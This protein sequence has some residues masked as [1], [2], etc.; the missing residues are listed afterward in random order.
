M[1]DMHKTYVPTP[2][3]VLYSPTIEDIKRLVN[4]HGAEETARR[5]QLRED[6]IVAEKCDPYRHGYEPE[7][8]KTSD[9]LLIKHR[10]LLIN[11]G[12]RA[13]KTEY[14]AKRAINL[15]VAFEASMCRT[16]RRMASRRTRSCSPTSR[17]ASL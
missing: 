1:S 17:S 6:K 14:A 12:N 4:E 8:W 9:K 15:L 5:L 11:G 2:H 16:P 3:P 13:G 7:H 10:E